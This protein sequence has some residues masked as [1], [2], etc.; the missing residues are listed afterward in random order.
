M[1]EVQSLKSVQIREVTSCKSNN[2]IR[3]FMAY[4]DKMYELS[5]QSDECD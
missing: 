2:F 5:Y 4:L 3:L 1:R